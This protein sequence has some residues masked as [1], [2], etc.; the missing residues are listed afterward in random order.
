MA[1]TATLKVIAR[2]GR[3]GAQVICGTVAREAA[4]L[5]RKD[6]CLGGTGKGSIVIRCI[7]ACI[8]SEPDSTYQYMYSEV[9][10]PYSPCRHPN[11]VRRCSRTPLGLGEGS[12]LT[13]V[14]VLQ[15]AEFRDLLC[16]AMHDSNTKSAAL[17]EEP[18]REQ[19]VD[20]GAECRTGL[21]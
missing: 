8:H 7:H 15:R 13:G 20:L 2:V 1:D 18:N 16:T 11:R 10:R 14:L 12:R 9:L 4:S 17:T 3:E 21:S 6:L 5:P 19:I